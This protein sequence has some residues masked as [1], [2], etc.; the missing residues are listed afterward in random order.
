MEPP[1]TLKGIDT[2][3]ASQF[4]AWLTAFNSGNRAEMLTYHEV[5]FP[6]DKASE[7]V[8]GIDRELGLRQFTG[9]FEF[10]RAE[11]SAA[12]RIVAILK[13][14]NSDQIA[15][16]A[17]DV[18]GETP[19]HVL[20]F[21]IHP[22][23]TPDDLRPC[24]MK[25]RDGIHALRTEVDRAMQR[26]WFSGAVLIAKEGQAVLAEAFGFADRAAKL[27]N[28]L[29]TRFRIASIGKM[30][31]AVAVMRLVQD[32]AVALTDP[33]GTILTDYPNDNVASKVTIH[34]LLTHTGGTGSIW[35]RDYAALRLRTHADYVKLIGSRDVEF[36]PGAKFEYSNYGFI[37]L[38]A[39]IEKVTRT[40]Y[41]DAVDELVYRPAGMT[42]TGSLPEEDA[43]HGRAIGYTRDTLQDP[44]KSNVDTLPYRGTANAGGYSTVTDL[45]A[46][47]NALTMCRLLDQTHTRLLTTGKIARSDAVQYA[48]G[49]EESVEGGIRRVG[50]PGGNPGINGELAICDSGYTVV[51]L[52]NM[53]PPCAQRLVKFITAR[54]PV[55]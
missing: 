48:Y 45:L 40:S 17:M 46:F 11:E 2:P 42:A 15:R 52:A 6:Y 25:E 8:A 4:A 26:D 21:D 9:G 55:K 3:A 18:D 50:H 34:H 33:I 49:F 22:I 7:D 24:R 39:I 37:V 16:A 29:N 30:F 13:E 14:R 10:K 38:G 54:L 44:W 32:R 1:A 12:T 5:K 47:A 36:E 51:I 43:V 28:T 41:D 19:N 31:T 23:S 53:D 27:P 20:K 35:M